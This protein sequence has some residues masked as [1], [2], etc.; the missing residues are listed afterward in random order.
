MQRSDGPLALILTPTRELALQSL[1]VFTQLLSAFVWIVPGALM[2][3]EKKKAEKARL[4]KGEGVDAC[5]AWLL[6]AQPRW[7]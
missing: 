6:L 1:E 3:G 2:G 4:R 5:I 7:L